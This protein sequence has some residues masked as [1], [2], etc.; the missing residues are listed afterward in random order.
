MRQK[1]E[2]GMSDGLVGQAFHVMRPNDAFRGR[3]TVTAVS[4][5]MASILNAQ[6]HPSAFSAWSLMRGL[7]AAT[8]LPETTKVSS[9]LRRLTERARV[10]WAKNTHWSVAARWR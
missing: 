9:P 7:Q 4:G 3:F 6:N 1:R 2:N 8:I 5:N 10:E